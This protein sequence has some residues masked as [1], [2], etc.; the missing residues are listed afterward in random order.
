M[1]KAGGD[2]DEAV[3]RHP[4]SESVAG[5]LTV[6]GLHIPFGLVGRTVTLSVATTQE[7][8]SSIVVKGTNMEMSEDEHLVEELLSVSQAT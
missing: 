5:P 8:A 6:P 4:I 7:I 3:L 1:G 2:S